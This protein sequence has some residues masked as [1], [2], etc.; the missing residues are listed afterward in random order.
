MPSQNKLIKQGINYTDKLFDEISKRLEQGVKSS[1][2]LESF[3]DKYHK[4]FPDKENPVISLGYDQA[5][6]DLI[7]SETNNHKFSRPSQ[8]E[9]VRVTIENQV[10]ELIKDVGDDVRD[11]VREIV[12]DGYN[13]N[14]SQDEI[15]ANI[16]AKVDSIK[17]TRA[18][19]IA[20]TEIARAATI[21]DYVINAERGA[22]H[23]YVEC[24]NTACPI[25]KEAWHKGWTE[26]ND[27]TYKPRDKSAGGKGWIGNNVYSMSNTSKLPPIHVNCR[28]VPYLVSEDEIPKGATIVKDTETKT[29]KEFVKSAPK[30]SAKKEPLIKWEDVKT[31]EDIEKY[32]GFEYSFGGFPQVDKENEI[33]VGKDGKRYKAG[34]NQNKNGKYHKFYDP[35]NDCTIYFHQSLTKPSGA[36]ETKG[37]VFIDIE[38]NGNGVHNL[39]D[40]LRMYDDAPKVLKDANTSIT[41]TN[42]TAKYLRGYNKLM[43]KVW[44]NNLNHNEAYT[45]QITHGKEPA[46]IDMYK[47]LF[48]D[49]D[50]LEMGWSLQRTL[51]HE[52]AHGLDNKLSS[53]W[54]NIGRFSDK[55][56]DDGYGALIQQQTNWSED[57]R[58]KTQTPKEIVD[59]LSSEYGKRH[60]DK[61]FSYSEDFADAVSMV[62]FK[63]IEDKTGATILPPDWRWSN[64]L[65]ADNYEDFVKK[66]PHKVKFIEELLGI[67][68]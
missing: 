5:L 45:T 17:N 9:L 6:L 55:R 60:Y 43:D 62:V 4:A 18:R 1:D 8:K 35:E 59:G 38:N 51:Y 65:P 41:F 54:T 40:I 15:A 27:A 19:A 39:K 66:Y 67:A 47:N 68:N 42:R 57:Y 34:V 13:N 29:I 61:T 7:L 46:W 3:L 32:F 36:K 24:R 63:Y 48:T 64:K 53:A 31:F 37:K 50:S 2:S 28:C 25:C 14:L 30:K 20:R 22:T 44:Q 49:E 52:M 12:K 33:L 26:E 16:S 11:S 23:F 10:G 58:T 56:T 21:S